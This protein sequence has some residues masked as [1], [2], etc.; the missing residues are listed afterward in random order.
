MGPF[1]DS[2]PDTV[3][4]FEMERIMNGLHNHTAKQEKELNEQYAQIRDIRKQLEDMTTIARD[5]YTCKSAEELDRPEK[6]LLATKVKEIAELNK[7]I[8]NLSTVISELENTHGTD[9]DACRSLDQQTPDE[10]DSGAEA[11]EQAGIHDS[12]PDERNRQ[13]YAAN[14]AKVTQWKERLDA[15]RAANLNNT[16]GVRDF[17]YHSSASCVEDIT[18]EFIESYLSGL[19]GK[20]KKTII[21]YR[22]NIKKFRDMAVLRNKS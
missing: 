17:L 12:T 19:V 11:S 22:C 13:L 15:F 4:F 2:L 21:G 20:G 1:D 8:D 9:N 16:A 14:A 5:L 3:K 10:I 7:T 6:L 18:D